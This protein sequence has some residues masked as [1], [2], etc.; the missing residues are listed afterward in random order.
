MLGRGGMGSV[1]FAERA[2]GE[3]QQTAAIKLLRYGGDE[4]GFRDRFLRER[5]ILASLNHS[6]VAKLLDAGHTGD[7]QPY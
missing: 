5:Q 2:D 4:P 3:V 7:G 6:G 1:Y